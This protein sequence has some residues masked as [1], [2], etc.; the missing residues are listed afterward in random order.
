[1]FNNCIN[2]LSVD[3]SEVKQNDNF[4]LKYY[5]TDIY[6][7]YYSMDYIFNNCTSLTSINFEYKKED[8]SSNIYI[9]SSKY[10][11]NN[12]YSLTE[13]HLSKINFKKNLNN[14]FSNCISLIYVYLNN[15]NYYGDDLNISYI[16]YNCTSLVSLTFPSESMTIP[17]DMSY[18]FAYCTSLK[19][20]ELDFDYY[21]YDNFYTYNMSNAFRNCTSLVS[22]TLKFVLLYLDM[23]RLFMGCYSLESIILNSKNSF[24]IPYA[25]YINGMFIDCY[26]LYYVS[27]LEEGLIFANDLI[28]ISYMFSGASIT[29]VDFSNIETNNIINYEGLFYDCEF[30]Y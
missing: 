24:D 3:F 30:L 29:E 16:F 25:K 26:S 13:L 19:N 7:Y 18:S 5:E 23:S 20:L 12:C 4:I 17:Q 14:M 6:D 11:F 8:N 1:M 27:F 21:Y 10:M 2:L 28:D 15:L 22:I 9:I